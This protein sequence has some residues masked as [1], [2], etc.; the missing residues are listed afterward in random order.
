MNGF[1]LRDP[2]AAPALGEALRV[3]ERR[4]LVLMLRLCGPHRLDGSA[5][6]SAVE[7]PL[8]AGRLQRFDAVIVQDPH[9]LTDDGWRALATMRDAGRARLVGVAGDGVDAALGRPEPDLLATSYHLGSAWADR[10]RMVEATVR[11]RTVIGEGY[12]PTFP[13]SAGAEAASPRRGLFGL[14]QRPAPIEKVD[15][16]GFLRSTPK[17]AAD[18]ICLAHALAEPALAS[19]VIE[20]AAPEDVGA[21]GRGDRARAADRPLRPDRDGALRPGCVRRAA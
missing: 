3:V 13:S 7:H 16:Y 21:P 8:L 19:V 9:R 18:E 4:M 10:N 20:A 14:F 5:V 17:W 12:Y 2:A 6:L 11:R 15:G 1:E